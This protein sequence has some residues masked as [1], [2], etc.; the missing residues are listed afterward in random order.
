MVQEQSQAGREADVAAGAGAGGAP[1]QEFSRRL[2]GVP[3]ALHLDRHPAH[4]G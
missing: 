2:R 1:A 4:E 3:D